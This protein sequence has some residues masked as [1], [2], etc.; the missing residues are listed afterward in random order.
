[1]KAVSDLKEDE[2]DEYNI[3]VEAWKECVKRR[4]ENK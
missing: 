4:R 3:P 2:L 1:M